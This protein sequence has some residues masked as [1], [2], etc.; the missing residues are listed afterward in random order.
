MTLRE[1]LESQMQAWEQIGHPCLIEAFVLKYG[2]EF[3]GEKRPKGIR[4]RKMKECF[5]NSSRML[6]DHH[7]LTYYEGYALSDK[8]AF[9]FLHAWNVKDGKVIDTTLPDPEN[10]Q[11][12]GIAFTEAELWHEQIKHGVYSMFDIGPINLELLRIMDN[13]LVEERLKIVN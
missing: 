13:D 10:Y 7:G 11:Y 3:R 6:T 9:P 5:A 12:I 1:M 2:T 4:K 8:F